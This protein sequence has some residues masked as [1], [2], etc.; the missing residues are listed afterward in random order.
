M[1]ELTRP[2][3]QHA[4]EKK[5]A[6]VLPRRRIL[7]L[8]YRFPWPLVGGDKVKPYHLLRHFA[9]IAD[10]DIIATDE[11]NDIT[12]EGFAHIQQFANLEIIPFDKTKAKLRILKG[13]A[14]SRPI[15]HNYYYSSE[16]H[17]AV[18]RAVTSKEYDLIVCFFLRT[19]EYV[20]DLKIA[21]LL[22]AEDARVIMQERASRKFKLTPE[23]LVRKIDAKR[24]KAYEPKMAEHFDHVTFVAE[25]DR[26]RIFAANP[27]LSTSV[28]SNGVDLAKF[29]YNEGTRSKTILF[30]GHLGIYHNKLMAERL[31]G[32]IFPLIQ[33]KLPDVKLKIVGKDPSQKLRTL[34]T[35]MKNVELHA[36][37]PDVAPYLMNEGIFVHPQTVG[38]GIQNKLL[39]A[40]AC[41]IPVITTPVGAGGIDGLVPSTHAIVTETDHE[42]ADRAIELLRDQTSS[43]SMQRSA[44]QLIENSFTWDTIY[45]ALDHAIE[46]CV[47][48]FFDAVTAKPLGVEKSV[49]TS[50]NKAVS[51]A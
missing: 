27:R 47:P 45:E 3:G 35:S 50:I 11:S 16:M 37:V 17:S 33:T 42:I 38:S 46:I 32:Q 5:I 21:K 49:K 29:K 22:I 36:D 24:L 30:A 31:V 51:L 18:N 28:V 4:N 26:A 15:E 10:V 39:E 44:R 43:L 1:V 8:L 20:K 25:E 41:G 6:P 19:A 23:Y 2:N 7:F 48:D 13:L 40:M 34:I 9:E 14:G 12:P